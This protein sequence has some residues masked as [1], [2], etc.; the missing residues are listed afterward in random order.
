MAQAALVL[1]MSGCRLL[2]CGRPPA[3]SNLPKIALPG[4]TS[5]IGFDDLVFAGGIRRVLVPAGR[6]GKVFL[7]DPDSKA[8]S[9]IDG[10][11]GS[12]IRAGGHQVVPTS[13]D[14]GPQTLFV[15]DRTAKRL[16]LVN[17]PSKV[18]TAVAELASTPD[19]VRYASPRSEAWVTEPGAEQIEIFSAPRQ[20]PPSLKH[21]AT[22]PVA[23]G[24]ESLVIDPGRK[25]AYTHLWNGVTIAIDLDTRMRTAQW[26]NGCRGSRGIALD[27]ER[28]YLFTGCDEGK[29]IRGRPRSGR[30]SRL[31]C[32]DRLRGRHHRFQRDTAASVRPRGRRGHA[33]CAG[34]LAV[35][36]ALVSRHCGDG[37][38]G[39]L[40]DGRR[41]RQR[42][43]LRSRSRRT[44]D[45]HRQPPSSRPVR[46]E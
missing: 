45:L 10:F 22:I 14:E 5:G 1:S 13:A 29:A 15:I 4:G 32:D 41:S 37:L 26:A 25:V 42:V 23:G 39:S 20:G 3:S 9:A 33:P 27:Q 18:V 11:S 28:G 44:A 36:T 8:V 46:P 43:D 35:R 21:V 30:R 7:L 24:P 6:T 17:E 38:R 19:Y 40:R 34:G 12:G 2:H 16:L 31:E